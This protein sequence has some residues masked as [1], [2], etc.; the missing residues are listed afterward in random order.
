MNYQKILE[1]IKNRLDIVDVIS[2]YI[3]LKKTGQNY[4]SLCPFHSEKTPSFFVNPSKQIFHCFGCGKGGDIV[5]FI[6]EYEKISF[7]EAL[8][9]LAKKA[10]VEFEPLKRGISYA[11]KEKLYEIYEQATHYYMEQLKS[12]EKAKLYLKSRGINEETVKIF[13]I[14]YAPQERNSL[15]NFLKEKGFDE[16]LINSSG[17]VNNS[18][19]F[20]RNRIVIPIHDLT[21]KV[22]GFGGR[23]IDSE[24]ELP[25]Y[26]NSPDTPIF[27]K[28]ENLFGFWHAKQYIREKGYV[29][30]VEGYMDVILCHQHGFKNA[31]APL[32]TALTQ[33]Q[34]EKT[35]RILN[36][37][38]K[39]T[40][41]ILLIFDGD[42]AGVV[43]AQRSLL[44]L[45][46]G[47]FI[48]KIVL[49]PE[50]ED[51]ASF[52]QKYGEKAF[53]NYLIKALSPVDLIMK[54]YPPKKL[55]EGIRNFLNMLSYL[56]DLI[57]RDELLRELSEKTGIN[58]VTLR[59]ELKQIISNKTSKK[60]RIDFKA[61]SGS[62]EEE[63]LLRIVLSYPEKINY[64]L[65][66]IKIEDFEIHS[67]KNIFLKIQELQRNS[68]F[69]LDKLL[70]LLDEEEKAFISKLIMTSEID[71]DSVI[72]NMKDCIKNLALKSIDKKIKEVA[73]LGDE[74]N[75]NE[76]IKIRKSI[77]R[78]YNG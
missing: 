4:K 47:G 11:Y 51:P 23:L 65:E 62:K 1:E 3:D 52:L 26:I 54:T 67:I 27:K 28:G 2:E 32:G 16:N 50:K 5:T 63:I 12:S 41:R 73:K 56:K 21:G 37:L 31:V 44:T 61:Y 46:N 35:K 66:K 14:G 57:Y 38:K 9:I 55:N 19:D 7:I 70:N 25:K 45:F 13:K 30:V 69:S 10:G 48:V 18:Y 68:E 59:E 15:C 43:A 71:E 74:K 42:E 20:F 36:N 40:N 77:I 39:F 53:K 76:L 33:E 22:I 24:T 29:M 58:E 17:L 34:L 60:E 72:Q 8:S 6:M 75:L 64:I 49:L 78:N